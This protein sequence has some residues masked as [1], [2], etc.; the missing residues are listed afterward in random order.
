[1]TERDALLRKLSAYRFAA[2][3]TA[4]FLDTH[5]TCAEALKAHRE[6]LAEAEKVKKEFNEKYGMLT[7]ACPHRDD[8]WQWVCDPWP[9][10]VE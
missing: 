5:P 3:E 9:W 8:Y 2:W 4:L 10:D 1:M 6:Y 7:H